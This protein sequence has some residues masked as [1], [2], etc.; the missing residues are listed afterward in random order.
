ME[1]L[2]FKKFQ[3]WFCVIIFSVFAIPSYFVWE[4]FMAPGNNPEKVTVAEKE[5]QGAP[6][7]G[8]RFELIDHNGNKKTDR[9]FRGKFLMI[10]F[11]Y[12][13]CPD[14]CPTALTTVTETLELLGPKAN[15]IQPLFITVD[16]ERDSIENLAEYV[17]H[18][19]P[20][21]IGLTGSEEQVNHAK[22]AYK[23][24][25]QKVDEGKGEKDYLIDHSSIIYI[26]DRQGNF[27]AHFNHVT[28]PEHIVQALRKVL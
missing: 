26:M 10:Y 13:Y 5:G 14:I 6:T 20:S 1:A 7:I 4:R 28:P 27:V 19:H 23:V 11:G 24:F 21:L 8:G 16:P 22:K 12:R 3:F 18:F 25:A 9:D 15:H 2:M 17:Q